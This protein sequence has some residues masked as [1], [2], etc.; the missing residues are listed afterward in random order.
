MENENL[1][2]KR[3]QETV[4]AKSTSLINDLSKLFTERHDDIFG[5]TDWEII[6]DKGRKLVTFAYGLPGI[7]FVEVLKSVHKADKDKKN[8]SIETFV[9]ESYEYDEQKPIQDR[10]TTKKIIEKRIIPEDSIRTKELLNI[11]LEMRDAGLKQAGMRILRAFL[12]PI[13]LS[14]Q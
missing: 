7:Y 6:S 12:P 13:N 4:L 5:V 14:I 8:I 10:F 2:S 1:I 3:A 9:A 11:Y